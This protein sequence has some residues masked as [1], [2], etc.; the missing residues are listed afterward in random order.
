MSDPG[1]TA[2]PHDFGVLRLTEQHTGELLTFYE[3]LSDEVTFFYRPFSEIDRDVICA[4]LAGAAEGKHI[5]LGLVRRD[6][7]ILGHAFVLSIG[8]EK[9]VFGIGLDQSVHGRG[10]GRRMTAEAL[11]EAE[12]HGVALVTLTVLKGNTRA[13]SL[14]RKFGFVIKGEASFHSAGDSYCMERGAAASP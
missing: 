11:A 7:T 8:G 14:Y 12:K 1:P 2:E 4:H 6:G 13:L 10:W 9:P 5:S 3:G